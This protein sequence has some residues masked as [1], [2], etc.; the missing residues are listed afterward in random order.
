MRTLI[1]SVLLATSVA[2]PAMAQDRDFRQ[3]ERGGEN[4]GEPRDEARAARRAE[5]AERVEGERPQRAD[6]RPPA[7]QLH[8]DR[9]SH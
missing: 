1:M 6:S 3:R 2:L 5:R 7:I 9:R 4:A 8:I